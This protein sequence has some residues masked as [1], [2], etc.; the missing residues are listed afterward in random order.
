M[1]NFYW[2]SV[3]LHP[4]YSDH[5]QGSPS[6]QHYP[7]FIPQ[8]HQIK[9]L[10]IFQSLTQRKRNSVTRSPPSSQAFSLQNFLLSHPLL[11]SPPLLFFSGFF[12]YILHP[13]VQESRTSISASPF[14][15]LLLRKLSLPASFPS[16][17]LETSLTVTVLLLEIINP[18]ALF[19]GPFLVV[20]TF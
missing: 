13:P 2:Y 14:E 9:E 1:Q 3:Y 8:P 17:L 4:C 11:L 10:A 6:I 20:L 7:L 15:C 18:V 12:L 19:F 16:L 5:L